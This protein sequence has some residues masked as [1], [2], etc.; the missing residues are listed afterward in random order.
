MT[1]VLRFPT[2]YCIV[3]IFNG[4]VEFR[5]RFDECW[6]TLMIYKSVWVSKVIDMG[7]RIIPAAKTINN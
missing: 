7:W 6:D 4:K 1:T 2:H 5:G 3:N